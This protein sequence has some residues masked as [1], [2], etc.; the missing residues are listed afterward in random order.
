MRARAPPLPAHYAELPPS[1]SPQALD[2]TPT[3]KS[4]LYHL[5]SPVH[6]YCVQSYET[7]SVGSGDFVASFVSPF[8]RTLLLLLK[9]MIMTI[10]RELVVTFP[11]HFTR[12]ALLNPDFGDVSLPGV[13]VVA[14]EGRCVQLIDL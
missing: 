12:A 13:K 3:A 4:V 14:F 1:F 7:L 8:V 2:F 5:R 9:I 6:V 10:V 11:N